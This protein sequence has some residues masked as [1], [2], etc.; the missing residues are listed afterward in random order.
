MFH[1]DSGIAIVTIPKNGCSTI[2]AAIDTDVWQVERTVNNVDAKRFCVVLRDPAERFMSAI[3]MY[4]CTTR[5]QPTNEF[6][7][8]VE[9]DGK[10]E[11]RTNDP[12][13]KKQIAYLSDVH[14]KG[15]PVDYFY[16]KD[17]FLMD[18]SNHYG[19]PISSVAPQNTTPNKVIQSVCK[20]MIESAYSA[21]Y[22]LIRG[23]KLI[24][25]NTQGEKND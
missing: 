11:L 20:E 6:A 16:L 18:I 13:F 4:M 21:D 5:D 22:D 1:P 24:N 3:N 17:S 23:V 14:A 9:R 15:T 12:H 7:K 2:R 25:H 8:I 10:F 19:I